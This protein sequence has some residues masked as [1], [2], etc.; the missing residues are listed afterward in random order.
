MCDPVTGRFISVDP[1]PNPS[2]SSY[3]AFANNPIWFTDIEADTPSVSSRVYGGV[4][5]TIGIVGMA[6]SATGGAL[7]S[8]TGVGAVAGGVGFVYS[9]DV[10]SAGLTQMITGEETQT[11]TNQGINKGLQASGVSPETAGIVANYSEAAIAIGL[12]GVTGSRIAFGVPATTAKVTQTVA[13]EAPKL[14]N[15]FNSAEGLIQGA[16]KLQPVT[17][18]MQGF[19]KGDGNA[20]FKTLT[21]NAVGRTANGGHI[22]KDGTILTKYFS[23]TTG[24]FTIFI[25]KG[26]NQMYKIRINQ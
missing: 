13:K 17:G 26:T 11:L 10:A 5:A 23:S 8:W 6:G 2:I 14:L 4:K 12:T 22:L 3:A 20:I 19:V 1:K 21:Q 16:G 24:E 9:A 15:Q 25:N 18:A 7:T